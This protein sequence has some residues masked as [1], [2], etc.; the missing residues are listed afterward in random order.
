MFDLAKG[1]I[2][3][4]LIDDIQVTTDYPRELIEKVVAFQGEDILK[5]VKE[6]SQVEISGFGLLYVAKGKLQKRIDRYTKFLDKNPDY[7]GTVTE[8]LE[9]L[10]EK[11]CQN[12]QNT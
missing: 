8:L 6:N 10:K 9:F 11:K 7:K 5:A 3:D 1:T 12:S 2:K 4:H